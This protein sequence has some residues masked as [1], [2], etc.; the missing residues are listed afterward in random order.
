MV[1]KKQRRRAAACAY[2]IH[3]SQKPKRVH[4]CWVRDW[5]TRRE[6]HSIMKILLEE[7]KSE[8]EECYKNFLRMSA[9]D[10][11]YLLNKI[12]F[13]IEKQNTLMRKQQNALL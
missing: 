2:V 8:D 11:D 12:R 9:D 10:F 1:S 4:K 5:I 13:A 3:T 6:N 7:L